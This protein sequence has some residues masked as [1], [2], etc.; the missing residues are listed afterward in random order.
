[1]SEFLSRDEIDALLDIA[2]EAERLENELKLEKQTKE[3]LNNSLIGK[4]VY[5]YNHLSMMHHKVKI[6]QVLDNDQLLV[7]KDGIYSVIK[8]K[9]VILSDEKT[10]ALGE[11]TELRTKRTNAANELNDL[12]AKIYELEKHLNIKIKDLK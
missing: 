8:Y 11:L 3:I 10:A 9:D 4:E 5:Y 7:Q 2:E 6:A 12:D 1:M